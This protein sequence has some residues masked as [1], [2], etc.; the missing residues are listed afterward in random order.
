MA[1]SY[2]GILLCE[3]KYTPDPVTKTDTSIQA[4]FT[5]WFARNGEALSLQR[6]LVNAMEQYPHAYTWEASPWWTF[7]RRWTLD[8]TEYHEHEG[9]HAV[10]DEPI[11]PVM[12]DSGQR[13]PP[14]ST[15]QDHLHGGR[16]PTAGPEKWNTALLA[17]EVATALHMGGKVVLTVNGPAIVM[18]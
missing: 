14:P 18:P 17:H 9:E 11:H 15:A 12:S 4:L 1:D 6:R 13:Q 10:A 8:C 7:D 3:P 5:Q 16:M 2:P